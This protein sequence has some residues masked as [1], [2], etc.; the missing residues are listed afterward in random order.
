MEIGK[1]E[2]ILRMREEMR[3]L[4]NNRVKT[5]TRDVT[6]DDFEEIEV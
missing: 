4:K 5:N 6:K 1:A 3:K 2:G